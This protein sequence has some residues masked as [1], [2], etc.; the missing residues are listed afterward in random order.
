MEHDGILVERPFKKVQLAK[1]PYEGDVQ[2]LSIEGNM[3]WVE[4]AFV[5]MGVCH[6]VVFWV[7]YGMRIGVGDELSSS[8]TDKQAGDRYHR[9]VVRW[10]Q[11]PTA[12]GS[13]D[14]KSTKLYVRPT[15]GNYEG[16]EDHT[17]DIEM[18]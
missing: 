12:V 15:F 2:S 18:R 1:I 5:T 14:C 17:F 6:A 11:D 9:Q 8:W 4:S 10:L 3:E 7:D 16:L 13:N